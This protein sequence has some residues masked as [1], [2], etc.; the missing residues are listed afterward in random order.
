MLPG[1]MLQRNPPTITIGLC[2]RTTRLFAIPKIVDLTSLG[3]FVPMATFTAGSFIIIE[4]A[5]THRIKGMSQLRA[6]GRAIA[7]REDMKEDR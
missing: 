7:T 5:P 6:R 2:D 1:H 3:E 4:K